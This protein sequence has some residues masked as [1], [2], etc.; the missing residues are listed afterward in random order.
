MPHT[1]FLAELGP[2]VGI[3]VSAEITSNPNLTEAT[4]MTVRRCFEDASFDACVSNYVLEHVADP[5]VSFQR[6]VSR[7]KTRWCVLL[8][9]SEPHA[10]CGARHR[11]CCRTPFHLRIANRL[12]ALKDDAH[13]PWPTVYRAN[14]HGQLK[15]L[16]L[17]ASFGV[18]ALRMF[19]A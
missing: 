15:R 11:A 3:D 7:A 13:D 1:A 9:D 10:L 4:F 5:A 12:R 8:Q 6:G 18:E 2:V 14:T 16:A 19:E 17:K